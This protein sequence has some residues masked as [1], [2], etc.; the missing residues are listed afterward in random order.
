M[1]ITCQFLK[2]TLLALP[3]ACAPAT[4]VPQ[5]TEGS[6]PSTEPGT[7]L[8]PRSAEGLEYQIERGSFR[9]ATPTE[10]G[11]LIVLDEARV[12]PKSLLYASFNAGTEPELGA[13]EGTPV[14]TA[15]RGHLGGAVEV[16]EGLEFALADGIGEVGNFS[17]WFRPTEGS[18]GRLV[19]LTDRLGIELGSDGFTIMR[20]TLPEGSDK[21]S[22]TFK[23]IEPVRYDEWNL[24]GCS[25][26]LEEFK[27]IR[28]SLNG[29]VKV[30]HNFE[31]SGRP[32]NEAF[33][34]HPVEGLAIDDLHVSARHVPSS[35][36]EE[37]RGTLHGSDPIR[38]TL[39]D[40]DGVVNELLHVPRVSADPRIAGAA[41]HGLDRSH[42]RQTEEGLT[43]C[44]AQWTQDHPI[45]PPFPRTTV[46]QTY[47]G[48]SRIWIYSGEV[49]DTRGGL[50]VNTEDVW[51]YDLVARTWEEIETNGQRPI[52]RC[53]QGVD[54]SPE[55][56]TILLPGGWTNGVRRPNGTYDEFWAFDRPT[57][58]W[59]K[60]PGNQLTSKFSDAPFVYRSTHKD[61]ILL[62]HLYGFQFDPAGPNWTGLGKFTPVTTLEGIE[63]WSP[64]GSAAIGHDPLRDELVVFGG[65]LDA[66]DG[67][68]N[69]S[70]LNLTRIIDIEER[71][72]EVLLLDPSPSP[73][74]RTAFSHHPRRD[75]FVLFG[76]T[77]NQFSE[78]KADLWTF[79]L[80]S[81]SWQ[82]Q[83]QADPPSARGGY[84]DLSYDPDLDVF[85]LVLGRHSKDLFL[86]DVW[87]LRMDEREPGRATAVFDLEAVGRDMDRVLVEAAGEGEL[88]FRLACSTDNLSWAEAV[89]IGEFQC[90][91][92]ARYLMVE[93]RTPPG[94]ETTISAI[95]LAKGARAGS[96]EAP[97]RL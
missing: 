53:H 29:S 39:R 25:W 21:Q 67:T 28:M 54:Y 40:A 78:R 18:R 51:E 89:P 75:R 38:M 84:Y 43:W 71:T 12:G 92:D 3:Y 23:S 64:S 33:F 9:R 82:E 79:D 50:M 60:L 87:R 95:E 1:Q 13:L 97:L 14:S 19:E 86:N 4:G 8:L 49:A 42:L 7:L 91:E 31:P 16:P 72:A 15:T 74:T 55:H 65:E 77:Q 10:T 61:F 46:P 24:L 41:L 69:H 90:T 32:E 2:L 17:F 22:R 96:R 62:R 68:Q 73:R 34:V 80:E 26:E 94:T 93:V 66:K 36:W 45:E 47:V 81:R 48:N 70:Y 20:C 44:E 76:G 88:E 83:P 56:D 27:T 35:E 52:G 6:T 57:S 11:A 37:L 85:A 63:S 5:S 59:R 30:G 58:T